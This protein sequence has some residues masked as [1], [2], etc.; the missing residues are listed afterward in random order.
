VLEFVLVVTLYQQRVFSQTFFS[1]LGKL[2]NSWLEYCGYSLFLFFLW[3][4]S[5]A[6]IYISIHVWFICLLRTLRSPHHLIWPQWLGQHVCAVISDMLSSRL[7]KLEIFYTCS[8]LYTWKQLHC[9]HKCNK[10]NTIIYHNALVS[11]IYMIL[12]QVLT[13]QHPILYFQ[14]S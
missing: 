9:G 13:P 12:L 10:L 6:P 2:F 8:C 7:I 11:L 14:S 5:V 3:L 1:L 4:S